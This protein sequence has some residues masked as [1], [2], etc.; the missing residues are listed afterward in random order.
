VRHIRVLAAV[1]VTVLNACGGPASAEAP[2][3]S[4]AAP[5]EALYTCGHEL[6]F[7]ADALA[8]PTGAESGSHPAAGALRAHLAGER[9]AAFLPRSN[10]RL[11]AET[12]DT[13]LF[14]AP[15]DGEASW[16]FVLVERESG[17]W[18]AAAWGG[19]E[20]MRAFNG[21]G[22]GT[23]QLDPA[24]PPPGPETEELAVLVTE[25]NCAS[26]QSSAGR[27]GGPLITERPDAVVLVFAV[28]PL[29][30]DGPVACPGNPAVPTT[31]ELPN[32]LGDRELLEG[33]F[34]PPRPPA[35]P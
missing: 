26:G 35:A 31:V 30:T 28:R 10:Y 14:M 9:E 5:G 4:E 19:C 18:S 34:L 20:P 25:R 7:P 11:V 32:P 16:A 27:I 13:A 22:V 1:V 15:T 21:A 29:P 8:A 17:G 24:A 2:T 33:A 6:T 3:T 12:R 23:W